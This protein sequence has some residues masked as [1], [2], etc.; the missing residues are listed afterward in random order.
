MQTAAR[1]Y[2]EQDAINPPHSGSYAGQRKSAL[3]ETKVEYVRST[4]I[5]PNNTC[6]LL[7]TDVSLCNRIRQ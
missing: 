4:C 5:L 1:V 2:K 3:E 6:I 7:R